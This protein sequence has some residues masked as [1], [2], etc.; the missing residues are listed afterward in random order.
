[1]KQLHDNVVFTSKSG[2]RVVARIT[3][4]WN[5]HLVNLVEVQTGEK[6]TS[7][8]EKNFVRGATGYFWE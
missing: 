5:E 1:M 8:P 2:D 4:V 3:H 7:V 6:H